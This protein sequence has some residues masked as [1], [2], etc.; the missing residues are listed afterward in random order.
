MS[1]RDSEEK[2]LEPVSANG[3]LT[4]LLKSETTEQEVKSGLAEYEGLRT[5]KPEDHPGLPP[6]T[7]KALTD[8]LKS[9]KS[10]PKPPVLGECAFLLKRSGSDV[11]ETFEDSWTTSTLTHAAVAEVC[12]QLLKAH[13]EDLIPEDHV[14]FQQARKASLCTTNSLHRSL[15]VCECIAKRAAVKST[16]RPGSQKTSVLTQEEAKEINTSLDT[17]K[18]SQRNVSNQ[19]PPR[20]NRASSQ[21]NFRFYPGVTGARGGH[22]G[23]HRG[24]PRGRRGSG[25]GRA[26]QQ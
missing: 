16:P 26:R 6:A 25:R 23:R 15:E 21:C 20:R 4:A 2:Q 14:L 10:L 17:A 18:K 5:S 24:R 19:A 8:E 3:L 12:V 1:E 9:F 13:Q 22:R 7:H 11:R